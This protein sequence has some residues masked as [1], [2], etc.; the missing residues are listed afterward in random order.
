MG[1]SKGTSPERK[2]M[3][4]VEVKLQIDNIERMMEKLQMQGFVQKSVIFESDTYFTHPHHDFWQ[5]DE[6]L[7]LR[8]CENIET[9]E[10]SAVITYKG[11]KMDDVSTTRPE[12]E[13]AVEDVEVLYRILIAADFLPVM[14]VKKKRISFKKEDMTV[15]LDEVE[16]L[17]TFM[18][19]EILV[20]ASEAG[21]CY[22]PALERIEQFLQNLGY[23][24]KDTTRRS[25]LSMLME[26]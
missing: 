10:K 9:K 23:S 5:S 15:C 25:Y 3:I 14:P 1:V 22:D 17:G 21:A 13:T 7:R 11:A 26:D 4:E 6:A 16:S 18:E 24:M 20:E 19:V 2:R 8:S 12:Y